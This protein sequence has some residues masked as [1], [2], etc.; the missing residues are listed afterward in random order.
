[1]F[2]SFRRKKKQTTFCY[3]PKCNNELVGSN[4]FLS[5]EKLVVYKCSKC[6]EIS[7]WFFETPVP[8]L[9]NKE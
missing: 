3:C 7:K 9:M 1:M 4:S 2:K 5:Y 6:E 8:I